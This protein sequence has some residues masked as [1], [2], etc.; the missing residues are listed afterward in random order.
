M[1]RCKVS[2]FQKTT[3]KHKPNRIRPYGLS[4]KA[5][6]VLQVVGVATAIASITFQITVLYPWHTQISAEVNTLKDE[7]HAAS[8]T[9]HTIH[10]T[11]QINEKIA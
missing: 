9:K 4:Q 6:D 5:R 11:P 3:A 8:Y 1:L 7:V 10:I 2:P